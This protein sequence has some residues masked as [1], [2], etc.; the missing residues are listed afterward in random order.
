MYFL[1]NEAD[2]CLY[3]RWW[4]LSCSYSLLFVAIVLGLQVVIV[5]IVHYFS[6]MS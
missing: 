1:V 3:S 2:F 4:L 5:I 6:V